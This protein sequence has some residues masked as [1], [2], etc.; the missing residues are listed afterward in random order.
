MATSMSDV[1]SS[2][3]ESTA[4]EESNMDDTSCQG[5]DKGGGGGGGPSLNYLMQSPA[6][7]GSGMM[8]H[9]IPFYI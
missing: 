6:R 2:G 8:I 1:A 7:N 4:G 5:S 9:S 3:G